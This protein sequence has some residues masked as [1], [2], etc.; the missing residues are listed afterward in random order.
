MAV[1]NGVAWK[2]AAVAPRCASFTHANAQLEVHKAIFCFMYFCIN[3]VLPLGPESYLDLSRLATIGERY[4][5]F[6]NSAAKYWPL[7]SYILLF[8]QDTDC[9][10]QHDD[11]QHQESP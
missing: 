3:N 9:H 2:D 8:E 10:T 7:C 6:L 5:S 4:S 1:G 11:D